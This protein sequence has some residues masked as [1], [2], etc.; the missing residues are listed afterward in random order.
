MQN[1]AI[2][3]DY[4]VQGTQAANATAKW[5]ADFKLEYERLQQAVD[6]SNL[7]QS[8]GH[9]EAMAAL[10]AHIEFAQKLYKA[11]ILKSPGEIELADGSM[12]TA[13]RSGGSDGAQGDTLM[14]Q[15]SE[16]GWSSI[17]PASCPTM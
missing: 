3:Y 7:D 4:A 6:A 16:N 1:Q 14:K 9:D 12:E 17:F 10:K 11:N 8:Q 13:N 2:T 5:W 15:Y